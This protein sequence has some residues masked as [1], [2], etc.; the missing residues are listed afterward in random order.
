M[1]KLLACLLALM[2]P[3]CA[4]ADTRAWGLTINVSKEGMI[5]L[6]DTLADYDL[7]DDRAEY[8]DEWLGNLAEFMSAFS[9]SA[10]EDVYGERGRIA[11]ACMGTEIF[12][13]DYTYTDGEI[14]M[15]TS[16]VPDIMMTFPTDFLPPTV[17]TPPQAAKAYAEMDWEP[18]LDVFSDTV[19]H[20]VATL[21]VSTEEGVFAGETYSGGTS[22]FTF[23][24]DDRDIA[25][26]LESLLDAEWPE[27]FTNL[28]AY[29]FY[30]LADDSDNLLAALRA[31]IRDTAADSEYSY[32]FHVVCEQDDVIG[33]S[34]TVYQRDTQIATLSMG[35]DETNVDVLLG[36]GYEDGNYYLALTFPDSGIGWSHAQ[37]W[38][39]P[40]RAGYYV[41]AGD[42]GNLLLPTLEIWNTGDASNG[43]LVMAMGNHGLYSYLSWE[44]NFRGE[45]VYDAGLAWDDET[46]LTAQYVVTAAGD[47]PPMETE[48]L[49]VY[50]MLEATDA[51]S[52][53]LA[54]AYETASVQMVFQILTLLPTRLVKW[55]MQ[56]FQ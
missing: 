42:E 4:L 46:L 37:L 20:W 13:M 32:V 21:D 2:L 38:Y 12:A 15:I 51:Q 54:E 22:R 34:L 24:L 19:S 10:V 1:K 33:L 9:L 31:N 16:I 45:L 30:M 41:T 11:Y 3:C 23:R 8:S 28:I 55:L 56:T 27:D 40:L 25:V 14:K 35:L 26:L 7:M 36:W 43:D 17:L 53:E 48:G 50:N 44:T 52:E 29:Y 39:D 5:K 47:L 18:V 49:Q 6:F